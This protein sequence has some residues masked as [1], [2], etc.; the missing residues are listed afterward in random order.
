MALKKYKN[1]SPLGAL[2]IPSI[3]QIVDSGEVFEVPADLA[4]Y[5]DGQPENFQ[6]IKP[7]SK[8]KAPAKSA[9]AATK[10]EPVEG[11]QNGGE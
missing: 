11:D 5:F 2:D 10:V 9:P 8:P 6:P 7:A 4:D 1:V 3:G